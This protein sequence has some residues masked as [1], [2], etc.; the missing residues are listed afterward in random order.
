MVITNCLKCV[1]WLLVTKCD[2]I[3]LIASFV[4]DFQLTPSEMMIFQYMMKQKSLCQ[5][6]LRESGQKIS[7]ALNSF[8]ILHNEL[9]FIRSWL[10]WYHAVMDKWEIDKIPVW[11]MKLKSEIISW[12]YRQEWLEFQK[13]WKLRVS[14]FQMGR[15]RI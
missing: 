8:L 2:I 9:V 14:Y 6:I 10:Y 5:R 1:R 12:N 3:M 7:T 4:R 13:G 11:Q 15:A